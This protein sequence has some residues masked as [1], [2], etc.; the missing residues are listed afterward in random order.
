M[1]TYPL[2]ELGYGSFVWDV[3]WNGRRNQRDGGYCTH[4]MRWGGVCAIE[5]RW[6]IRTKLRLT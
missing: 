2:H 1:T 5:F 4:E 6:R 3:V